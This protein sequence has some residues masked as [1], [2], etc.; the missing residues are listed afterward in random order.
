MLLLLPFPYY[1]L[2]TISIRISQW[3]ENGKKNCVLFS[4]F[5]PIFFEKERLPWLFG[6]GHHTPVNFSSILFLTTTTI[7]PIL[8]KFCRIDQRKKCQSSHYTK[9][10]NYFKWWHDVWRRTYNWNC[11]WPRDRPSPSTGLIKKKIIAKIWWK[12]RMKC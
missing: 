10:R 3:A 11:R 6:I 7:S 9:W 5:R 12:Y 8:T 4:D 2:T 1:F